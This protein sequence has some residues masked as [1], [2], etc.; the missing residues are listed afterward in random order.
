[1][2]FVLTAASAVAFAVV[3]RFVFDVN[4]TPYLIWITSVN[5]GIMVYQKI[6]NERHLRDL[7][8]FL[9]EAKS[10]QK[11]VSELND[12]LDEKIKKGIKDGTNIG[13]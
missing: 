10:C 3:T 8:Q 9:E 1:M 13:N 12:K 11:A 6:S 7:E 5:V 2:K 4:L